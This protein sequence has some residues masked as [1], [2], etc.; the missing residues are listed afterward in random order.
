M[1][2][3]RSGRKY[4]FPNKKDR[5]LIWEW[6]TY[7]STKC[8]RVRSI[9][10]PCTRGAKP[11][12]SLAN[13]FQKLWYLKALLTLAIWHRWSWKNS[14]AKGSCHSA[15][16]GPVPSRSYLS[17]LWAIPLL[18]PG[19][20]WVKIAFMRVSEFQLGPKSK[21]CS[22]S[23]LMKL[24]TRDKCKLFFALLRHLEYKIFV[25]RWWIWSKTHNCFRCEECWQ[26]QKHGFTWFAWQMWFAKRAE[27]RTYAGDVLMV[28]SKHSHLDCV[29]VLTAE[30]WPAASQKCHLHVKFP[31]LWGDCP[32]EVHKGK[33]R[34]FLGLLLVGKCCMVGRF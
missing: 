9:M 6:V 32:R 18:P 28:T 3:T 5:T 13:G 29:V 33:R 15:F 25:E 12:G 20:P 7:I 23:Y 27:S 19:C 16:L 14:S 31:S 11:G 30:L 34:L 17:A 22:L 1:Q 10:T 21:F 2:G 8:M 26:L 4:H 24:P